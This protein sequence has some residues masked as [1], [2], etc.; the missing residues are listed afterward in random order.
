MTAGFLEVW[1]GGGVEDRDLRGLTG[2]YGH[3]GAPSSSA[4]LG[5]GGSPEPRLLGTP[6]LPPGT[7]P[8]SPPPTHPEHSCCQWLQPELS[9]LP[10]QQAV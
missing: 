8:P 2:L 4:L 3:S 6:Q 9:R 10:C 1:V 5:G 7:A